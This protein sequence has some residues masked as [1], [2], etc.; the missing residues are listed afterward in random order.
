MLRPAPEASV[1]LNVTV[2][3]EPAV[4]FSI[5]TMSTTTPGRDGASVSTMCAFRMEAS[6]S[7]SPCGMWHCE[8]WLSVT[9]G[10]LT[11]PAP[12]AKFTLSWQDPH[13]ARLGFFVQ[14]SACAAP[15]FGSWQNSQRA[16]FEGIST[17][18]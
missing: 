12:V 13:A 16:G 3:L 1:I 17:V 10:R 18:E 6:Y 8:H 5:F 2:G 15:D 7:S 11:W 9:C 4:P 14:A